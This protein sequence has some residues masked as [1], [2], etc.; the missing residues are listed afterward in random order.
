MVHFVCVEFR[1]EQFPGLKSLTLILLKRLPYNYELPLDLCPQLVELDLRRVYHYKED[2][3]GFCNLMKS[4]KR[5]LCCLKLPERHR[6][7]AIEL[8]SI[9]ECHSQTLQWL[10][11]TDDAYETAA[12]GATDVVNFINGLCL[13]HT[14]HLSITALHSMQ[15][16][17]VHLS[18]NRIIHLLVDFDS[19]TCTSFPLLDDNI[20]AMTKLSLRWAKADSI[21]AAI[22][23]LVERRLLL[24][25]ICIDDEK[26][27]RKLRA[28]LPHI[29]VLDYEFI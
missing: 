14:L 25:T 22:Y 10:C 17:G 7:T 3:S 11:F 15:A 12:Y 2:N 21:A 23:H 29:Q 4:L 5:G 26:M 20:P 16:K 18:S 13:L 1:M 28:M 6:F 24:M 8:Q 9:V 27:R 19:S